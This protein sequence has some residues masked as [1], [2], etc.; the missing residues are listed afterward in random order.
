MF[1]GHLLSNIFLAIKAHADKTSFSTMPHDRPHASK[2]LVDHLMS[3]HDKRCWI[4]SPSFVPQHAHEVALK[5]VR[6]IR[7][8]EV[9]GPIP[10]VDQ[11]SEWNN[12]RLPESL[13]PR[14]IKMLPL[15]MT[16][17]RVLP[18]GC[19]CNIMKSLSEEVAIGTARLPSTKLG[20][21]YIVTKTIMDN[22]MKD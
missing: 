12:E 6:N 19:T 11:F 18:L 10:F 5:F 1:W 2:I 7:K 21:W 15:F 3:Q 17:L 8:D 20:W 13:Y 14:A 4:D 22:L 16:A 9:Y